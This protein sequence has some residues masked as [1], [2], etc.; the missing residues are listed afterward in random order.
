[1]EMPTSSIS[2]SPP[3]E[4]MSEG[5]SYILSDSVDSSIDPLIL[6]DSATHI[7]FDPV[8]I[9]VVLQEELKELES[10]LFYS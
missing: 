4:S 5:S 3:S 10:T 7:H 9:V 6:L 1:M 8:D 2:S